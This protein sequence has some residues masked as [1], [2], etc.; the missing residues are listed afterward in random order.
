[1]FI[2]ISKSN[3]RYGFIIGDDPSDPS[4]TFIT[5]RNDAILIPGAEST[6]A[7]FREA[8]AHAAQV[9][10]QYSSLIL[11]RKAA[12]AKYAELGDPKIGL[13]PEDSAVAT[14]E[15]QPDFLD[16]ILSRIKGMHEHERAEKLDALLKSVSQSLQGVTALLKEVHSE[17]GKERLENVKNRLKVVKKSTERERNKFTPKAPEAPAPSAQPPLQ[18]AQPA[19]PLSPYTSQ[20][21]S[22]QFAKGCL[23]AFG[24]AAAQSIDTSHGESYLKY[25][26]QNEDG[27]R[28]LIAD[29]RQDLCVLHFS[30]DLLLTSV[31]PSN[32]IMKHAAYHSKDFFERYWEPIVQAV[33]HYLSQNVVLVPGHIQSQ[34]RKIAGW[35]LASKKITSVALTIPALSKTSQTSQTWTIHQAVGAEPAEPQGWEK[36]QVRCTKQLP[37]YYQRTG[38]VQ[39]VINRGSYLD[40]NVDFGRGL[41]IV[42][43][44]DN[45]LEKITNLS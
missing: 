1:M 10:E 24:E 37:S 19:Q 13:S 36:A 27:Y 26:E 33:G 35:N 28:I 3:D 21:A 15:E 39:S 32:S 6:Y 2:T 9:V 4:S 16:G 30:N 41:G 22:L 12:M 25:I 29:Q 20:K 40:I 23:Q 8:H 42:T 17:E 44:T 43:M 34:R 38:I 14:L 11:C 45:D 18:P 7:T 5:S 31:L